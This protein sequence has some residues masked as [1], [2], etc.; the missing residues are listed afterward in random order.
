MKGI[1]IAKS[2]MTKKNLSLV[3]KKELSLGNICLSEVSDFS[4]FGD[5]IDTIEGPLV[6]QDNDCNILG[7]AHLDSVLTAIPQFQDSYISCPQLDDR[8]GAWA[9]LNQFVKCDVLL[10]DGEESGR[11]TGRYFE[12]T[13]QYNWIFSFDRSGTDAVTYDYSSHKWDYLINE[14]FPVGIGSFS[15]ISLMEHLGCKGVNIGIGYHRQHTV[16]CY[17][18]MKDTMSQIERFQKFAEKNRDEMYPHEQILQDEL[19]CN[20]CY[21][22]LDM[23]WKFCPYCGAEVY[24]DSFYYRLRD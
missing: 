3:T 24:D 22:P 13:K 18:N 23:R 7:I 5:T 15:D 16:K 1:S 9:L 6:Y 8:L 10:T 12:P 2:A 11:S 21:E 17:A 20:L 14:F 19:S 4:R